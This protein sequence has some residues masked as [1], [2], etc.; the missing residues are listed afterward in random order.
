[1]DSWPLWPFRG[2]AIAGETARA[3]K[4][5]CVLY[6]G[7]ELSAVGKDP[8]ATQTIYFHFWGIQVPP[9]QTGSAVHKHF[10]H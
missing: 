8:A 2:T 7:L 9:E 1:M 10:L 4:W 5:S 3:Y 6:N